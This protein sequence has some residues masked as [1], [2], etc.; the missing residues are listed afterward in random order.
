MNERRMEVANDDSDKRFLNRRSV[1]SSSRAKHSSLLSQ[2][3]ACDIPKQEHYNFDL[4]KRLTLSSQIRV[5]LA[6]Y[7]KSA[8][9]S[10]MALSAQ[11]IV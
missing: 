4:Q 9:S 10:N 2:S 8:S 11:P 1:D 5:L 7:V 3:M 6:D